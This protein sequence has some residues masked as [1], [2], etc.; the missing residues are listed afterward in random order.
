MV[1]VSEMFVRQLGEEGVEHIFSL[2][3]EENLNCPEFLRTSSLTLLCK[4]V[5]ISYR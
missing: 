5:E 4:D 2:P 3:G 1:K